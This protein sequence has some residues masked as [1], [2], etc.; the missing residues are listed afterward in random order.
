ML[1]NPTHHRTFINPG[2]K[3]EFQSAFILHIKV[4][5]NRILSVD[6]FA[7][8]CIILHVIL[9]A[10]LWVGVFILGKS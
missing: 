6:R 1:S 8:M 10:V 4:R 7:E 9:D 3:N 2:H 5:I